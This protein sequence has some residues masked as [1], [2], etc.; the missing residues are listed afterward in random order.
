MKDI[1]LPIVA[2]ILAATPKS[3]EN[4]TCVYFQE[5]KVIDF[6]LPNLTLPS[7]VRRILAPL[8]SRCILPFL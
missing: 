7:S 2:V 3:A 6:Y 8:I 1:R 4:E 5:R